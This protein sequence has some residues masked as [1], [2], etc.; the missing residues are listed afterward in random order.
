VDQLVERLLPS[1]LEVAVPPSSAHPTHVASSKAGAKE[2][3]P[4]PPKS[5]EVAAPPPS[6]PKE[7]PKE[8]APKEAVAPKEPPKES[9]PL[10]AT[11]APL[12]PP[13][14]ASTPTVASPPPLTP[15]PRPD[16]YGPDARIA[17]PSPTASG[18]FVKGRVV[19]HTIPEPAGAYAG[20]GTAATQALYAVMQRKLQ[21]AVVPMGVG[22]TTSSAAADEGQRAHA[23]VVVMARVDTFSM[24]ADPN[25]GTTLAGSSGVV[26]RMRLDIAVMREG[27]QIFRRAVLAE[28]PQT[29]DHRG[30]TDPVYLAVMHALDTIL[31]ELAASVGDNR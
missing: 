25:A 31:P 15:A 24:I 6:S 5:V 12:T 23:A 26:A 30:R 18:G 2:A 14:V 9:P 7:P 16:P 20:A 22:L 29:F 4:D 13:P 10:V 17:D 11:P 28:T 19:V 27:R 21:R 8:A 3:K 1:C